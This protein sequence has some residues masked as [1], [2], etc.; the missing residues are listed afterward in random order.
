[1]VQEKIVQ[2]Y[3][4][5]RLLVFLDDSIPF[6]VKNFNENYKKFNLIFT[7][8]IVTPQPIENITDISNITNK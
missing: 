2:Q 5:K 8:K 1:M 3:K 6:F 7:S 4:L